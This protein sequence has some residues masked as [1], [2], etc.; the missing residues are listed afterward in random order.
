MLYYKTRT[1]KIS[2]DDCTSG[3]GTLTGD[4]ADI[5][6]DIKYSATSVN[7]QSGHAVNEAVTDLEKQI[8]EKYGDALTYKGSKSKYTDLPSN[9]ENQKGDV[10][11]VEEDGANYAWDGSKW[12]KLS[13][14]LTGYAT[15]DE[16]DSLQSS[17]E[18]HKSN[19]DTDAKH[20]TSSEY[21]QFK[22]IDIFSQQDAES[23]IDE[24]I[25][26]YIDNAN[27]LTN[28]NIEQH[29]TDLEQKVT[30]SITDSVTSSL[31]SSYV[32]N[33]TFNTYKTTLNQTL[34]QYLICDRAD[35]L[36]I[37][38]PG[39][40]PAPELSQREDN[41]IYMVKT[42]STPPPVSGDD[43]IMYLNIETDEPNQTVYFDHY[44]LEGNGTVYFDDGTSKDWPS[45][46][47]SGGGHT[48]TNKGT[49][50]ITIVG[51][52]T[53]NATT[54]QWYGGTYADVR[55]FLKS[56]VIPEGYK[57]PITKF[58]WEEGE[59]GGTDQEL[60]LDDATA[61]RNATKL[62][63]IDPKLLDNCDKTKIHTFAHCFDGCTSLTYVPEEMFRG[64]TNVKTML[65]CFAGSGITSIPAGLFDSYPQDT[66]FDGCFAGCNQV[67][68]DL[69]E[70]WANHSSGKNC[71]TGCYQANNYIE[72]VSKVW[73]SKGDD[74]GVMELHIKTT[75]NNQQ[76]YIGERLGE[77]SSNPNVIGG[78]LDW[79]DNSEIVAFGNGDGKTNE[80]FYHNY[81]TPKE[82]TITI[83]GK[84]MWSDVYNVG[85]DNDIKATLTSVVISDKEISPIYSLS[86][87][88]NY[89]SN[90]E[91]LT[92]ISDHLFDNCSEEV[93][94]FNGVFYK[95]KIT[96]IPPH[97]FEK[98]TEARGFSGCFQSC[99]EL[100]S[101]PEDL[102]NNCTK[103]NSFNECF[104]DCPNLK[105]IPGNLFVKC[106]QVTDFS[107]CFY[108]CSS[109]TSNVPTLWLTHKDANG[110][111]CFKGCTS[112]SN[113]QSI[114]EDW[115][116]PSGGGG[117]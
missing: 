6:V 110:T 93:T 42:D 103:V 86:G 85:N 21:D 84:I 13:E 7:P 116:G 70:L 52:Y 39:E 62:T 12:D 1:S 95:T 8:L 87:N 36:K 29:I 65:H 102:F 61:F 108:Y 109:V 78:T 96:E 44:F 56:I 82:Y 72:A 75:K 31:T 71:F 49:H 104:R 10:W 98:Y 59:K 79:G 76:V 67:T 60:P 73:A 88:G 105:T 48:Y 5:I 90:C 19:T 30:K 47:G 3:D 89:F 27:F 94:N 69:P 45:F 43:G 107:G 57:S 18:S 53:L 16:F 106:T 15:K 38:L 51:Q 54:Y 34:G 74:W 20:L 35:E 111:Y 32:S 40:E 92:S 58:C 80:K 55:K 99:H 117:N 91:Q 23:Y 37:F 28:E 83:K 33:Q 100:T 46:G 101:I 97:L 112:A 115:G 24:K 2:L 9:G 14:D 50:Q 41:V 77:K 11:N 26:D 25:Q 81:T 63:Y 113:Y 66:K 22:Q 64:C 68:G 4:A 114:P 17:F